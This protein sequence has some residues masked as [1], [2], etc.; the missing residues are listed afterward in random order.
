MS[1]ISR[2]PGRVRALSVA[3][4]LAL[5]PLAR[6]APAAAVAPQESEPPV[7]LPEVEVRVPRAEVEKDPTASATVVTAERFE[8]EAKDVAQLLATAPGVSVTRYGTL[9]Q[10][11]T[12][13]IRGVA[14]DGVKVLLDGLP[15]GTA[16]GGVDLA[17]IPRQWISRIEVV[18]GAAGAQFGAGALGGAVNVVTRG[19]QVGDVSGEATA[20]A[21]GTYAAS[22]DTVAP[23]GP[24]ALFAAASGEITEGDF[25]YELDRT[26]DRPGGPVEEKTRVNNGARRAGAIAK[27]GG[28]AGGFRV[29]GLAQLTAGR[30]ELPGSPYQPTPGD[31]QEDG[32]VL[33][34]LRVAREVRPRLTLAGRVHG[35]RDL[36]DTE[37]ATLGTEPTRQRG[38]AIGVEVEGGLTHGVGVLTAVLSAEN[39]GYESEALGGTRDRAGFAGALAEDLLLAGGRLRI[40]ASV[41]AERT[42]DFAGVSA[43]LGAAFE[44][45]RGLALRASGG[46]TYRVPSFAELHLEQ[47]L[48]SPN[49]DLRP[50]TGAGADAALVYDGALGLL[51]VGGHAA[52]YED[53][54]TYEPASLGHFRP[55]N[56]GRAVV[57]G[58]EAE[59]ATTPWRRALGLALSGA[60]TFLPTE[61]LRGSPGVLGNALPRRPLHRLY[62]RAAVSPGRFG[63]H[64]QVEHARDQYLGVL[65]QETP[66]PD[67]TLVGAGASIRF[68]RRPA[69]A[70][71]VEVDNVADDRTLVDGYGNPLP[72]RTWM[73]TLRAASSQERTR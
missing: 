62:A 31:W 29:D 51:S 68:L 9:G 40:G 27:L 15:L 41:R 37:L 8:G 26:P 18:R 63:A 58:V 61:V 22:V 43:K 70:L 59:A 69:L 46:R 56:T 11:A 7:V 65:N 49:P 39:E 55:F 14:A 50:E 24:F 35:R 10:L 4:S 44:L 21:F 19:G 20:G 42:G 13:S 64:V 17:T 6:A 54:I 12:V 28:L 2:S 71:H 34:M 33:A 32:R 52:V 5:A 53:I 25:S 3:L 23:V 66:L 16:G 36:L 47:G 67:V 73:V 38:G 57:S 45:A 1:S 48:L 60:Y 72:G 30:R